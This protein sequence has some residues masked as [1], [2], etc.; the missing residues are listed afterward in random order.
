MMMQHLSRVGRS[1]VR[2]GVLPAA[3]TAAVAALLPAQSNLSGQGYGFPTGQM[4]SRA[5]GAGGAIA[6]MDPLSAVN[7]ST[8]AV[9]G[10]RILFF[11]IEPEYRSVTTAAGT[12]RTTTARYPNIFGAMPVGHGVVM[13][14]GA[15]TLLD[16]TSTTSF[17]TT[18]HLNAIDSV[19]MSTTYRIDGAMDDVRLAGAWAPANWLRIGLGMHAITG[20]NL[21]TLTQSFT[22]SVQ[23]APFTQ[24]RVLGFNGSALSA[25]FQLLSSSVVASGSMRYGGAL[26]VSAEDTVLTSA[27][28]PNRFGAS[29]AYV[30]IA[31]SAISVR[32]SREDWSSLGTLGSSAL[33]AVDAWDTSVGADIAGPKFG[34]KLVYLRAGYR[35]RTLPFQAAG[36]TVTEKSVSGGLGTS[37]AH[38]HVLADIAL[39]HANRTAN[40]IAASEHAWTVSIGLS[41]RP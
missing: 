16:R 37:F 8:I 26:H 3:L 35:D 10:T 30:G 39:I 22:D 21:V 5:Q 12:E 19:P 28:V 33:T 32:T 14:L 40:A 4:S 38:E 2:R 24:S 34:D 15:S 36:Q 1:I 9:L 17:N 11:Q 20:H 31:N 7:P 29:L 13:S 41:V 6:E 18:Q 25:G 23:F 27:R